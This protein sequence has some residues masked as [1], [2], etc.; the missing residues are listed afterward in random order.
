MSFFDLA[1]TYLIA[2][3]MTRQVLVVQIVWLAALVPAMILG[4]MADGL[5]GAGWAHVL[6]A[7]VVVLPL[8]L[9]FLHRARVPVWPFLR[10]W[11]IPTAAGIPLMAALWFISRA[12]P[13][14]SWLWQRRRERGCWFMRS[15]WRN[16]GS[17]ALVISEREPLLQLDL[18]DVVAVLGGKRVAESPLAVCL[19]RAVLEHHLDAAPGHAR[20]EREGALPG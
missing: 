2:C 3:G 13:F 5:A 7:I 15:R 4:V 6:V 17:G 19:D 8:Y 20:G 1:A 18:V 14:R 12:S 9:V 10:A 16:G 11:A